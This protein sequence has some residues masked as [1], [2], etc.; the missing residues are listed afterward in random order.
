[1]PRNI[2]AASPPIQ[3][4]VSAAFFSLGALN[5]GVVL[6]IASTP[7]SAVHPCENACSTA[8]RPMVLRPAD[9][10]AND[11][12]SDT[13]RATWEECVAAAISPATIVRRMEPINRYDG[14]ANSHPASRTPLKFASVSISTPPM[15]I[16]TRCACKAGTAVIIAAT[17]AATDT[18]TVST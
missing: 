3:T 17:P 1:M 12:P 8:Y 7:V 5:S 6:E 16:S 14:P 13:A 9:A 15:H 2:A 10:A 4:V 18:A 11:C